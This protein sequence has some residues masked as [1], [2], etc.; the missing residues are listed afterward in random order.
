MY[1]RYFFDLSIHHILSTCITEVLAFRNIHLSIVLNIVLIKKYP[2][3]MIVLCSF[4]RNVSKNLNFLC[5]FWQKE[6]SPLHFAS[7]RGHAEIVIKLIEHGAQL[8]VV[9]FVS[10]FY[11]IMITLSITCFIWFIDCLLFPVLREIL[12]HYIEPSPWGV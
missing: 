6:M 9:N 12:L 3:V 8:D 7:T 2:L 4:L 5:V 10:W 11:L 1:P